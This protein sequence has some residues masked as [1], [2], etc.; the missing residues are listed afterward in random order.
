M[1]IFQKYPIWAFCFRWGILVSLFILML[2][3]EILRFS[4]I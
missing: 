3:S 4:V 2:A 1:E